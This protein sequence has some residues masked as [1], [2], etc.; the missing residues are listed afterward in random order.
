MLQ[1]KQVLEELGNYIDDEVGRD[2]REAIEEHLRHCYR[3]SVIL[4]S[5]RKTLRIVGS[6]EPFEIPL[7]ASAR[8]YARVQKLFAGH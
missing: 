6:A 5:T 7:G 4:D 1:C 3:C 2:L 8:L